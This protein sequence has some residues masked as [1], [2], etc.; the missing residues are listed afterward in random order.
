MDKI[1]I[2]DFRQENV[3]I[4]ELQ[5]II[6]KIKKTYNSDDG[7]EVSEPYIE[8]KNSDGTINIS[9]LLKKYPLENESRHTL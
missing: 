3:K 7:W 5:F 1:Y 4:K 6:D 2:K 8:S 9:V